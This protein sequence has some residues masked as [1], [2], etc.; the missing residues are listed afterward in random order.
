FV[1][2][3]HAT[4]ETAALGVTV[5]TVVGLLGDFL[6]IPLLERVRGLSYL[7][8]SV[9]LELFLLP[10]FLLAADLW[11]KFVLVGLLGFFNACWYSIL[12]GRLYT[13]MPGQ[14]GTVM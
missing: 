9:V 4:P 12:Q 7:R 11:L 8:I 14:S 2:V 5:W 6:L 10:A 3:A 13:A 1:D